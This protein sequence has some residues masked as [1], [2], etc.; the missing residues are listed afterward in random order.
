VRFLKTLQSH[1][2]EE[3]PGNH[4]A[5]KGDLGTVAQSP[6]GKVAPPPWEGHWV[7]WDGWKRAAFGARLGEDFD[8]YEENTK[9][10][11]P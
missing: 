7:F 3:G 6:Y 11:N 1:P 2:N 8:V 5:T 4:Y 9:I 10:T